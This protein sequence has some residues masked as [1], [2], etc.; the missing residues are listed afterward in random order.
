M[1]IMCR[2]KDCKY[3][4]FGECELKRAASAGSGKKDCVYYEPR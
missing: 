2:N 1:W 3:H 4:N